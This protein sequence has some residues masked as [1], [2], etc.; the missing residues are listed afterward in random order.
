MLVADLVNFRSGPGTSYAVVERG[1][2]GQSYP[3][4]ALDGTGAW[5]RLSGDQERWVAADLV[6]VSGEVAKT[7]AE[8]PAPAPSEHA[9]VQVNMLNI[10][11]GPG[12]GYRVVGTVYYGEAFDVI[13]NDSGWVRMAGD[14]ERWVLASAVQLSALPT[15]TPP[16]TP[17]PVPPT[18]TLQ[19]TARPTDTPTTAPP[20]TIALVTVEV[21][22]APPDARSA[23]ALTNTQ[24][25]AAAVIAGA[26]P[27]ATTL[28]PATATATATSTATATEPPTATPAPSFLVTEAEANIRS[29]PGTGY[30]VIVTVPAGTTYTVVSRTGTGDWL[31]LAGPE[32]R[33]I[34]AAVGETQGNVPEEGDQSPSQ[35]E[36]ATA[37]PAL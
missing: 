30:A 15:P 20:P 7:A 5:V 36:T 24:A 26:L 10:R 21:A 25:L 19:P 13:Q 4:D 34:A 28:V 8:V 33:W 16:P 2:A 11:S 3:V 9:V 6:Q 22:A 12:T 23:A 31:R 29:G 37:T 18:P 1:N 14:Q 17:T 35:A 27:A 32:E